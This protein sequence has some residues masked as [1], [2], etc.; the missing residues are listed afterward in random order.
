MRTVT[1]PK[2]GLQFE[3]WSI[4]ES[5]YLVSDSC[6]QILTFSVPGN[7]EGAGVSLSVFKLLTVSPERFVAMKNAQDVSLKKKKLFRLPCVMNHKWFTN[8]GNI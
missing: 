3:R 4:T 5:Q 8:A 7:K 6:M 2:G 1:I